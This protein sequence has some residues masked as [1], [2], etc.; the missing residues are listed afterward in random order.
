MNYLVTSIGSISAETV[1]ADIKNKNNNKVTGCNIYPKE[2]TAASRLTDNFYEVPPF[3]EKNAYIE[4]IKK[5][6]IKEKIN[7]IV[8]LTDPEVDILSENYEDFISLGATPCIST[9]ASIEIARDKLSIYNLFKNS[10]ILT[11]PTIKNTHFKKNDFEFPLIAKLRKG[12]SSKGNLIIEN[13]NSFEFHKKIIY[14]NDYIIQPYLPGE[15]YVTD[16]V[17]QNNQKYS[18]SITRKELL[19]TE[20]GAGIVVQTKNNNHVCNQLA[21]KIAD[22][23]NVKGCINI[24]FLMHESEPRIMD[25]NPRF[26]A[27]VVF[28]KLSGYSMVQNH[29]RC[30]N[31]EE[32]E[33]EKPISE[34]IYTRS[35]QE[36]LI[37]M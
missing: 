3:V 26:S 30:F 17:R 28:S 16:I 34:K 27:G 8:P 36:F 9:S 32:I 2:W 20:N 10:K 37:S 5:I 7:F 13:S 11:I 25:I 14:S 6:I 1:I 12:R 24:E 29:I 21:L 15:I 18:V 35:Y 22:A 31:D 4:A 19:R 33:K 23:I